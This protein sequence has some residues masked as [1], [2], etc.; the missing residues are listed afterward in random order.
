MRR[1]VMA[2]RAE[3][4]NMTDRWLLALRKK[5]HPQTP[6]LIFYYD[7]T[8]P[9]LN[10]LWTPTA[11]SWGM[12]KRWPD[13]DSDGKNPTWRSLGAVYIAPKP[14]KGKEA[15]E[16]KPEEKMTGGA[17]TLLEARAKARRWLDQLS[18]GV[19][20]VA[21]AKRAKA[22]NRRR[23]T[24]S[25]LRDE[26]IKRHWRNETSPL[27]KADEAERVL[28]REFKAWDD[29]A[30]ADI[31]ADDV[32]AIMTAIIDRPAVGQARNVFGYLRGLYAWGIGN[33]RYG[34]K[35]SPC[36]G[37]SPARMF[38][39][40]PTRKRWL[41]DHE[42]GAVWNTITTVDARV[43][44]IVHLLVLTACRLNEIA[45]LQWKEIGE[46]EI[47]IPWWRMKTKVDHLIPVTPM[48][49]QILDSVPRNNGTY[50]FSTTGGRRPMTVGSLIKNK[51]DAA[52]AWPPMMNEEGQDENAWRWHDLRRTARTNF[53]K[54]AIAEPVR[55]ALLAHVKKGI[56]KNYD[57][58][59]YVQEKR[60]GLMLWEAALMKIVNPPPPA[61]VV[62]FR[63][64]H[65]A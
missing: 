60:D 15:E 17:L 48:I 29:R 7:G 18:R 52:L 47:I 57:I 4:I 21:E 23:I 25:E 38:G 50:V 33:R 16:E 31:T 40:K 42:L 61:G 58:H 10:V 55:E 34:L 5:R 43:A 30:A 62:E 65:R 41:R 35:V 64:E 28:K 14:P 3:K 32:D 13:K 11:L 45:A 1:A 49:R 36:D 8:C 59:G 51:L 46:H 6:R 19:D 26:H 2:G 39:Q 37:F 63:A 44:P 22:E 24:F 12:T 9:G 54:L 27:R 53:S 20:P 56:E